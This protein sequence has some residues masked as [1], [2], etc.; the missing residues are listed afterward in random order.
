[1][2]NYVILSLARG[3]NGSATLMVD[4]EIIWYIEEERLSRRKYDGSPLMAM[5]K[6]MEF[7]DHIDELIVCHTHRHGASLDWTCEDM[8]QGWLRKISR[9][10]FQPKVTFIDTI[11]HQMHAT[12]AFINSGFESAACLIVDGAGSFLKTNEE[13]CPDTCFE[14]ETIFKA[15][16]PL[17]FE[18]LYKHY[19]T[20]YPVGYR[21]V[22]NEDDP[23]LILT[24][25]P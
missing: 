7:V 8:Y 1:M 21:T 20:G 13:I 16:Y 17:D 24:D 9:S 14:F 25:F 22:G 6:A 5:Q 19:G 11:H 15:S 2:K 12:T 18:I 3:H 4:G 23:E 10:K